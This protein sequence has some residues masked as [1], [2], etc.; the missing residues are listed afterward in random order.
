MRKLP[1]KGK[2]N[3]IDTKAATRY[4][5]IYRYKRQ[6]PKRTDCHLAACTHEKSTYLVNAEEAERDDVTAP[7]RL[8][9]ARAVA[10][11]HAAAVEHHWHVALTLGLRY[12]LRRHNG[13]AQV[14]TYKHH[15]TL[16]ST[17][18]DHRKCTQHR[19]GGGVTGI[20]QRYEQTS[21]PMWTLRRDDIGVFA[22]YTAQLC[23]QQSAKCWHFQQ[24]DKST[25]AKGLGGTQQGVSEDHPYYN[26]PTANRNYQNI[27]HHNDDNVCLSINYTQ[28]RCTVV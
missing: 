10:W 8:A 13:G 26:T 16:C 17:R 4:S 9:A 15:I 14:K 6:S 1:H 25:K 21:T 24:R 28:D 11:R 19:R 5:T 2:H 12:V 20:A 22:Y 23:Y 18:R 3:L 27:S 7:R